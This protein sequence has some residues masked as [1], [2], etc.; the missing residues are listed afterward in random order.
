[1]RPRKIAKIALSLLRHPIYTAQALRVS[2]AETDIATAMRRA[3]DWLL[4]AQESATDGGGYPR[5]YSLIGGWDRCYIETTGYI[6]PTLLD[7]GNYLGEEKYHASALRAA[8]WLLSVQQGDGSFTDIDVYAPQVFDT[9]Q[10]LLGLNRMIRE[11]GNPGYADAARRAAQW[12]VNVQDEDG[13][14]RR[15]AYQ[16]RPHAYYSR[17]GAALIETGLLLGDDDFVRM[18]RCN[19]EWVLAQE[20][21][22]GYYAYSEFKPGEDA[23]LHT[24]VYVLEGFSM[25]Y[26]LTNEDKW[27]DALLRGVRALWSLRDDAGMLRSQYDPA[28]NVTNNEYCT[29]GLAQYAGVCFDAF[30][31]SGEGAFQQSAE[32]VTAQLC[33]WQ[34]RGGRDIEG[35]LSG[36]IPVWGYYGGMEYLNWN[37]K[38]FIDA[39]L[40]Q[41]DRLDRTQ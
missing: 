24:I 41:L 40:K 14:W 32:L 1:M 20:Q 19:L 17:V 10:V 33:K 9:G 16:G 6:I 5:R 25:A 38:F 26:A 2:D 12:L 30:E 22:N 8:E 11:G 23:I 29:T 28:F 3:A 35:G 37:A 31:L 18:G 4:I 36:S 13:A 39:A 21:P 7:V 34:Q 15:F 27:R